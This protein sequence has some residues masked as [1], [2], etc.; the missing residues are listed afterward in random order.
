M[1]INFDKI[2]KN[3]KLREIAKRSFTNKKKSF[4][5]PINISTNKKQNRLAPKHENKTTQD[6][7]FKN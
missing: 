2:F 1:Y 4:V 5:G 3:P 6:Q 7:N